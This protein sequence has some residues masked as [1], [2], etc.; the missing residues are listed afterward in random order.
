MKQLVV[1][2][3][4]TGGT[5][6]ANRMAKRLPRGWSL[7][8]VDPETAHLYQPGLLFTP[9]EQGPE[10]PLTKPRSHTL[11]PGLRWVREGVSALDRD[12]RQV[13]LSSGDRLSYDL[14]VVATGARLAPEETPGLDGPDGGGA[15]HDFYTLAGAR[16]LREAL[17]RFRGGR[18]VVDIVDMP[19]KCP[20]APLEFL[21][22]ADDF[23]R[24]RGLRREVELVFAT[25][26][27][28]A[29]TR[30]VASKMLGRL[31]TSREIRVETEFAAE[32][33]DPGRRVLSSWD[34]REISYDLL[35]TVPLHKGAAF[36][37]DCGLGN[38]SGFV[39]TE[40]HTLLCKRD[41]HIFVLGDAT[42]LPS[43]KAGSVAHF[44]AEAL[45][46]NLPRAMEGR[47]LLRECDGHSNC[48]V[49]TGG[50]K[51]L[52][53]DFN[54]ETEPL[55]GEFPWP[56][57]G[58]IPLMKETRRGHWGKLAFRWVYWNLLLPGRALP[59]PHRMSIAGKRRPYG[60]PP[61][62]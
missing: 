53:I 50:G 48:F 38:E 36:L 40:P 11:L 26:L 52:L 47:S 5:T 45:E 3:A 35:V 37:E 20:V 30:P 24:R 10:G 6:V 1:L 22:L 16:R 31:L 29:F 39:P 43:S 56:V 44:Q 59:V 28:G 58:P 61:A 32:K 19:V 15:I 14:L 17:A 7:T 57:V 34:G 4:G 8:V 49:E 55:P 60:S 2:G 51:A 41:D 27:D 13:V 42:D 18:V 23:F 62:A 33:V 54:D 12:R 21:F 46:I 25:P 9:F